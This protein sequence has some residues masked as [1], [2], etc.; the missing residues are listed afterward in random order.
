M[1]GKDGFVI[2]TLNLMKNVIIIKY[3]VMCLYISICPPTNLIFKDSKY[4]QGCF[5]IQ[6]YH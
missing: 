3:S 4:S 1:L 6:D 5:D 2:I